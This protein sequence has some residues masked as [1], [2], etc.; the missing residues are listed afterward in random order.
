MR[1]GDLLMNF[2][3]NLSPR[4]NTYISCLV[5]V[6]SALPLTALS[7]SEKLT[8]DD[9]VVSATRD[10]QDAFEIPVSVSKITQNS[11]FEKANP[12]NNLTETLQ[13]VPGITANNRQNYAQDQQISIRG[14]GAR[15][16]SGVNGVRIIADGIPA[17]RPDGSAQ[18]SNLNISSAESIEVLR[19]P[20]S[21]LYGNAAGGVVL[22]NSLSAEPGVFVSPTLEMG[23]YGYWKSDNQ[24][25]YGAKS[26]GS[27][28]QYGH[29][30]TN[31][32]RDHSAATRDLLN[33]KTDIAINDD[34]KLT[35]VINYLNMPLS[36]DPQGL[37][38]L[39]A[40]TTPQASNANALTYNTR[41]SLTQG[42]TGFNWTNRIDQQNQL[43]LTSYVGQRSLEQFLSTP[44]TSQ[45][46]GNANTTSGGV[47]NL[48]WNYFGVDTRYSNVQ[49]I[50]DMSL[51]ISVGANYDR[52]EERRLGFNNYITSS[53]TPVCGTTATCGVKGNLKRDENNIAQN[54]DQYLQAEL[55]PNEKW[56]IYAGLRH[57][58]VAL[59]SQD[60]YSSNGDQ[61]GYTQFSSANPIAGILYQI[62]PELNTYISIGRGF[63]TPTLLQSAYSYGTNNGF[64]T[65]LMASSSQQIET[66]IKYRSRDTYLKMAVF[67]ANTSNEIG[68]QNNTGGRAIYQNVGDTLRQ[69]F[70]LELFKQWDH[71]IKT[72]LAAT[73][74]NA[75]YQNSFLTCQSSS[76]CSD[77][78]L[79]TINSGNTLPGIAPQRLFAELSWRSP[80]KEWETGI[81]Y[82]FSSSIFAN[83]QNS[84]SA[85]SYNL[86]NVRLSHQTVW[87]E[88]AFRKFIRIDN[89]ANTPYVGSV[90]VNEANKN[91]YETSPGLTWLVGATLSYRP[92]W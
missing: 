28:L 24:I 5:G 84:E 17:S 90:I 55:N 83:D 78:Q 63:E 27:F 30:S 43:Q 23:S 64:N 82:R 38:A 89:I 59:G 1:Y 80:S 8:L 77:A 76:T 87:D 10:S 61:S 48:D 18:V 52:L 51:K 50:A 47:I 29:F 32:Y 15:S 41:K 20:F 9:M 22:I 45:T 68:V 85:S 11:L 74:M 34:Q 36:Y 69:G 62:T 25:S 4:V 39:Q 21:A 31:G 66:G 67:Q 58:Y 44:I 13:A 81:E 42:Q 12:N 54:F 79:T 3:Q 14:F 75:T 46:G 6:I 56:K 37:N 33:L 65:S 92:K 70:E 19:G 86:F 60:N 2:R 72:V 73:V 88:W 7:Q 35:W 91:Y 26:W 57:S 16:P 71:G 49:E 53:G 40:A